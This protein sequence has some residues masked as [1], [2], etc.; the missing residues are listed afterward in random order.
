MQALYFIGKG[1]SSQDD[2][3]FILAIRGDEESGK[4]GPCFLMVRLLFER[5]PEEAFSRLEVPGNGSIAS[6]VDDEIDFRWKEPLQPL[7]DGRLRH[8]TGELIGRHAVPESNNGGDT[9]HVE[10]SSQL[11]VAVDVDLGENEGPARP[12]RESL[13]GWP[14][15]PARPAPLRPEVN[16]D[17]DIVALLQ[18]RLLK[19]G[20]GNI[21]DVGAC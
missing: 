21:L 2:E 16:D 6:L 11:L 7:S 18:H 4:T 1:Q 3:S 19:I 8:S 14:Q 20:N 17:G 12:V 13:Q 9:L 15:C 10:L 5:R